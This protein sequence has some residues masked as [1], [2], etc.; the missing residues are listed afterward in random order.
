MSWPSLGDYQMAIQYPASCF[1]DEDLKAGTVELSGHLPRVMS[2]NFATVYN[3][4]RGQQRWAVRCFSHQVT[5]RRE[6]YGYLSKYLSTLS[7]PYL[8]RFQYQDEG[9]LVNG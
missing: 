4:R 3:I 5:E 6:R 2:G 8:A 7:M 1:K 9:I